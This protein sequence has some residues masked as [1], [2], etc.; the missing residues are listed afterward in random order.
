MGL[1]SI[2]KILQREFRDHVERYCGYRFH[3]ADNQV[4][5]AAL[6]SRVPLPVKEKGTRLRVSELACMGAPHLR[7]RRGVPHVVGSRHR[8]LS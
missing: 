3:R 4:E 1:R 2:E 6:L 5:L 7:W 8:D